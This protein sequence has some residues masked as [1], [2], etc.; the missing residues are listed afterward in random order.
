MRILVADDSPVNLLLIRAYLKDPSFEIHT[1]ANGAEAVE[2]FQSEKFDLVLMDLQ[3]PIMDGYTAT[4]RIRAWEAE[5]QRHPTPVLALTAHTFQEEKQKSFAAGCN[6]H[7]IKPIR[8]PDLLTAIQQYTGMPLNTKPFPAVPAGK[9]SVRPPAG[10]EEAIPLFLDITRTDLQSLEDALREKD[11]SKI[12][13][14]GHDLK[15][16]GGGY[17]FEEISV[18]GRFIEEAAKR[19]DGDEIAKQISALEDYLGRVEVVH[20]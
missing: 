2:K 16:S 7:L 5:Q 12:R 8:K 13:F 9:I 1:A 4:E 11:Y 17:G 6:A 10:I 15:G 3:M 19:S 14:I 18:I 20:D